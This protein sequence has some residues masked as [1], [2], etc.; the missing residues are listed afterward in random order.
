MRMYSLQRDWTK[1]IRCGGEQRYLLC[2]RPTQRIYEY[3]HKK[4]WG[5][6]CVT[7]HLQHNK[8][9]ISWASS[10]KTGSEKFIQDQNF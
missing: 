4:N 3:D 9:I 5:A 10:G 8:I 1:Q 6:A 7:H 2:G